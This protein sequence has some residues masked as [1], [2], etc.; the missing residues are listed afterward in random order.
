LASPGLF[1]GKK[2]QKVCVNTHQAHA[3]YPDA[4]KGFFFVG[5]NDD[6]TIESLNN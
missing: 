4:Q 3:K 2:K 1:L 5:E 6:V